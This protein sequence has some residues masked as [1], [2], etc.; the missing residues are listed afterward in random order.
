MKKYLIEKLKVLRQL[1]V[2][3]SSSTKQE[4]KVLFT[5]GNRYNCYDGDLIYYIVL[6]EGG[7]YK[8][9]WDFAE[10][11]AKDMAIW[12]TLIGL[13][14]VKGLYKNKEK[15]EEYCEDANYGSAKAINKTFFAEVLK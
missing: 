15:A 9:G 1:F 14:L 6:T 8:V 2:R 12:Q 5:D 4:K 7:K 13:S 10:V 3:R 11:I